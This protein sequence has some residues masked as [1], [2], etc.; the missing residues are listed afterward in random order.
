MKG[1]S[2]SI[3]AGLIV[4]VLAA[5]GW[6]RQQAAAP[7]AL[8]SGNDRRSQEQAVQNALEYNRTGFYTSW[9]NSETGHGGRVTPTLTYRNSAGRDC[10]KF[11]RSLSIDGRAA[12]GHGTRCRARN[13]AWTV[14]RPIYARQFGYPDPYYAYYP[15]FPYFPYYPGVFYPFS[16][17]LGYYF[18]HYSGY[19]GRH[20]N[21]RRGGRRGRRR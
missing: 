20:G 2:V 13:G 10:R 1:P 15:R 4:L 8:L 17:S 3:F 6:A 5:P 9:V 19:S 12:V 21:R 11:N 14:P 16:I 18:G 7:D